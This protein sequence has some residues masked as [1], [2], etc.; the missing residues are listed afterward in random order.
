MWIP[1]FL[2]VIQELLQI[3]I[4]KSQGGFTWSIG[5]TRT[6]WFEGIFVGAWEKSAEQSLEGFE[7]KSC[8][9][10]NGS[11]IFQLIAYHPEIPIRLVPLYI[12]IY[13]D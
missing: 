9:P 2:R 8:G 7:S 11:P 13:V 1:W 6:G 10:K 4:A 3:L 12:Y 5:S